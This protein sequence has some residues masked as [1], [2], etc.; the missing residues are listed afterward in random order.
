M[1]ISD[2][3][4]I[5]KKTTTAQGKTVAKPKPVSVAN[6]MDLDSDDSDDSE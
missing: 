1:G 2:D 5:V 6:K 3:E 4:V